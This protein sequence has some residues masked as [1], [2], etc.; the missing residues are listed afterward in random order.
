MTPTE[1][2]ERDEML[3]TIRRNL[4]ISYEVAIAPK[5]LR[6]MATSPKNDELML[7]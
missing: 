4:S 6:P 5:P 2:A 7:F 3:A 1:H